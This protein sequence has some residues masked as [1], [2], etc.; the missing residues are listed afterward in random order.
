MG[1]IRDIHNPWRDGL[2]PAQYKGSPFYV[3]NGSV[4][5]GRRIVEH[6]FPK[7]DT[8]YAEDM[9]QRAIRFQVRAYCIAY[10]RDAGG[11]KTRDYRR[12]R[13]QLKQALE[14]AGSG[15]LQ[16]PSL[17]PLTVVCERYRLTEEEKYGGYCV[18]D[19]SFA[20]AGSKDAGS[21]NTS[22]AT[23]A[24]SQEMSTTASGQ[25]TK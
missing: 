25:L 8:P 16:L 6:E 10:P 15:P 22:Q 17:K 20:E 11:L 3:D 2:L 4:E 13:D 19:I 9:G 5:S 14:K 1:D 23:I 24:A 7:R 18:F 12:P 21:A